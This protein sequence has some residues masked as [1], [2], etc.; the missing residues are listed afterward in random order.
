MPLFKDYTYI[1]DRIIR[2][3]DQTLRFYTE[4]DRTVLIKFVNMFDM[5]NFRKAY[6]YDRNRQ[7]LLH[8]LFRTFS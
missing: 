6:R 3:N 2:D 8:R 7:D 4:N 1:V 5:A